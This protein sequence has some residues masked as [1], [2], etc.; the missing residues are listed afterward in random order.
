MCFC[1]VPDSDVFVVNK[2][3]KLR[4]GVRQVVFARLFSIF[5]VLKDFYLGL[6]GLIIG[7]YLLEKELGFR[8]YLSISIRMGSPRAR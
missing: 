6:K 7:D 3:C 4:G 1:R 5:K 2:T 8:V